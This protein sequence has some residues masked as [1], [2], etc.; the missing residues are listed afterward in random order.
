MTAVMTIVRL[1]WALT[2]AAIRKSSGQLVGYLIGLLFAIGTVCGTAYIGWLLG[3]GP[4]LISQELLPMVES[5]GNGLP[6]D[7]V[8]VLIFRVSVVLLGAFLTFAVVIM[9]VMY[10]GQSSTLSPN[11][12]ALYGI[13]DRQLSLG[14]LLAGLTG[15]PAITGVLS[16]ALWSLAYRWMGVVPVLVGIISAP[17]AIA[18][19]MSLSKLV[20]AASTSLVRSNRG[21]N[22]FYVVAVIGC[23]LIFQVPNL[24]AN[25]GMGFDLAALNGAAD[26]FGWTPFA[27]PFA[28][29]F[30]AAAGEWL[31][32]VGHCAVCAATVVLCFMGTTWCLR[33]DRL[34]EGAS[35]GSGRKLQGLGLFG[36]VPDSPSGAISARF[37][38][39]L[40]RDPRQGMLFAMPI[41][42][43]A[44]MMIQARGLAIMPW[45]GLV[46][47]SWFMTMG[48]ANGLSYD[49]RGYAMEAIAGVP[50]IA[51]RM[52]RVRTL[53]LL[54]VVYIIVLAAVIAAV[55]AQWTPQ[56]DDAPPM[57]MP[58]LA[59]GFTG[60]ALGVGFAGIGL[61]EVL[62][63]VLM[64]P[65]PAIDK[66]FSTPQGRAVAQ[67]FFP[68]AQMF[69]AVALMLPTG[70]AA[71]LIGVFAPSPA[72]L[73]LLGPIA[74][75]NGVAVLAL[76]T[77]LGGK[78]LDVRSLNVLT[79][80]DQFASLQQ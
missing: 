55:T 25:S 34:T 20:I 37:A 78:L 54:V 59:V 74:L 31:A 80:L 62:S 65:V 47:G 79:T 66:P 33:H 5:V 28:L 46:M 30:D 35:Y 49:G 29:P 21:K 67:G 4:D 8:I 52:G 40:R 14:L 3:Q 72:W 23:V 1:R 69:G 51:D 22:V 26:V 43:V 6:A 17:I 16:I 60:G 2:N 13:P 57:P 11:K 63:V 77:W 58:L 76:G 32:F 50:G 73:W 53:V 42:F 61:A 24:L 15:I 48:E 56:M 36:W 70:V 75:A 71:V 38:S 18:V 12:F 44:L 27:A 9:Q 64:Y 39:Y 45:I 41:I 7:D 10:L 19:I 68:L